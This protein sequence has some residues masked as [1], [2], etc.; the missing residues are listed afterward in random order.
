MQCRWVIGRCKH[1]V[2]ERG[3]GGLTSQFMMAQLEEKGEKI[4]T[5]RDLGV[6]Y[7]DCA[8]GRYRVADVV[9]PIVSAGSGWAHTANQKRAL[10]GGLHSHGWAACPIR[11]T[12]RAS[13]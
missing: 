11:A 7:E 4:S 3:G 5:R 10:H 6:K 1:A 8:R 9:P 12:G 13:V 2:A